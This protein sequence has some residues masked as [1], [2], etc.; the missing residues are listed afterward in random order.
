MLCRVV[1]RNLFSLCLAGVP[2]PPFDRAGTFLIGKTAGRARRLNEEYS[3]Y[4]KLGHDGYMI[5]IVSDVTPQPAGQPDPDSSSPQ[6]EGARIEKIS[7]SAVAARVPEKVGRGIFCTGQVIL[8]SPK[9]FVVDFLQGITRPYQVVS[10]VV[11]TPKTVAEL[12]DA[13]KKNLDLYTQRFGPPAAVPTPS[14]E[15]RPTVAEIYEN[16]R[17]P[18][19]LLSGVY[20][21][22]VMIGHSAT[23][24]FLD[25]ITGFYPTS[26]VA[27]R[28]FLPAPQLPRFHKALVSSLEQH[29][30]RFGQKND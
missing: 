23:E 2:C 9:E 15:R 14:S 20:S 12:T 7:H 25:F 26:A 29:R 28:I 18:E 16:F 17:L 13:V 1:N 27:A 21:N 3:G 5:A 30:A 11:M 19:D 10:R 24:F 8:D 4:F 22:S 6:D